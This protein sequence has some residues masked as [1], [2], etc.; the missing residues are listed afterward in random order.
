M[1]D[2]DLFLCWVSFGRAVSDLAQLQRSLHASIFGDVLIACMQPFLLQFAVLESLSFALKI[3]LGKSSQ[4][5]KGSSVAIFV[6]F[7]HSYSIYRYIN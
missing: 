2:L 6:C 4:K 7:F 5:Q 3:E 1:R